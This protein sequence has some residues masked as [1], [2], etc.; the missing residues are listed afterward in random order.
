MAI[1]LLLAVTYSTPAFADSTT[2]D[3][4]PSVP[5]TSPAPA[6]AATPDPVPSPSEPT[7]APSPSEP[8]PAPTPAPL[9]GPTGPASA[10]SSGKP[11]IP[12]TSDAGGSDG[13]IGLSQGEATAQVAAA[14]AIWTA[15][16]AANADL[17]AAMK[18]MDALSVK[19]NDLLEAIA[20][21]HDTQ[22]SAEATANTARSELDVVS[23]RLE[24]AREITRMWAFQTYAQSNGT[25][26]LSSVFDIM[27]KDPAQAAPSAGDLAYL[28]DAR[29]RSLQELSGLEA[30]QAQLSAEADRA[31]AT[32]AAATA[33]LEQS[34]AALDTLLATQRSEIDALRT[35]QMAEIA[36][37][38]PVAVLLIGVQTPQARAAADR[39]RA[40][41]VA[42]SASPGFSGGTPCSDNE[43]AYPN[44]QLPPSALCPL[45][46]AAGEALRPTAA[47]AFNAMS[48]AYAKQMGTALCVTDS[49][50]TLAEQFSVKA[51]RGKW[52]ATPGTSHHGLGIAVDLCGGIETFGSPQHLWM[53]LNAPLYGWYHPSWAEPN[54]TLPEPWH[55]EFAG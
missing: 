36:Q 28:T 23:V 43:S 34:K 35:A 47:A 22:L 20:T 7:P 13:A 12:A 31:S 24:N 10:P 3:P 38:G 19:A 52:A 45:W 32:A 2:P 25:G 30:R 48:Q 9:P 27:G 39:L 53:Q 15:L 21:A 16:T 37:A 5:A 50:R 41:L 18:K 42:A 51:S 4:A 29:L 1:C 54:G 44:G 55:W 11:A 17:A 26:D 46:G 40:A 14:D 33:T 6:P 8:A 49:Y